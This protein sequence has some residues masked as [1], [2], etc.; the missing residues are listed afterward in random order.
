MGIF[1]DYPNNPFPSLAQIPTTIL[2]TTVSPIQVNS[3]IVCNRGSQTIRFNLKL[4]KTQAAPAS[5]FLINNFEIQPYSTID[6]MKENSLDAIFL[7]YSTM[8]DP[9]ISD[10]L[11]CFS[12]GY[13][14]IF[15]CTV[16]FTRINNV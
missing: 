9:E 16:F 7:E 1:V 8:P 10:S 12:N 2:E 13:T 11:V 14:Q 5:V 6:I 4:I 15:D 3:L